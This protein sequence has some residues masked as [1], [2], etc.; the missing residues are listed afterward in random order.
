MTI[1]AVHYSRVKAVF[2]VLLTT[3]PFLALMRFSCTI[4]MIDPVLDGNDLR[5]E[6]RRAIMSLSFTAFG[7]LIELDYSQSVKISQFAITSH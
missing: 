2:S 6:A 5:Q 7:E 1:M 4:K 3:V